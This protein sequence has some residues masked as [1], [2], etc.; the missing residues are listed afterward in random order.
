M[1]LKM[2][3]Q[4][5]EVDKPT[6]NIAELT[7]ISH[8]DPPVLPSFEQ[9]EI[10]LASS[11]NIEILAQPPNNIGIINKKIRQVSKTEI[12]TPSIKE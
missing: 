6:N 5:L 7:A 9:K 10:E 12:E 1:R 8:K 3:L 11:G 2:L 4:K